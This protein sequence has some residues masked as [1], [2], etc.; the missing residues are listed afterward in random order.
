MAAKKV[1]YVQQ[2]NNKVQKGNIE[3]KSTP[4]AGTRMGISCVPLGAVPVISFEDK[5]KK[6]VKVVYGESSRSINERLKNQ[7]FELERKKGN[8]L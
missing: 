6:P 3:L 7:K 8:F 5:V 4:I 2:I 1:L